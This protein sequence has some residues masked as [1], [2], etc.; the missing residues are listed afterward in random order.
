MKLE[1]LVVGLTDE[2]WFKGTRD[3]R[4]AK[5]LNCLDRVSCAGQKIKETFDYYPSPDELSHLN[6][7]SLEGQTIT[8]GVS[9]LAMSN[10]RLKVRG[11]LDMDALPASAKLNGA[12]APAKAAPGST[13]VQPAK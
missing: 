4:A 9:S 8:I 3:E 7:A 5:G 13:P 6:V 11:K 12:S 1:V 2:V 10:G